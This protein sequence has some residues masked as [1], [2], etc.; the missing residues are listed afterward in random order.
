MIEPFLIWTGCFLLYKLI[1][2]RLLAT[3]IRNNYYRIIGI[4]LIEIY[5]EFFL[6]RH[7]NTVL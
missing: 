6:S 1:N 4:I 7:Y 3:G 5:R 2:I